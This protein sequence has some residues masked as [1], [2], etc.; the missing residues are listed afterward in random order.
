MHVV[1]EETKESRDALKFTDARTYGVFTLMFKAGA[2]DS[3][4]FKMI[5]FSKKGEQLDINMYNGLYSLM[6]KASEF[7]R[8][9]GSLTTPTCNELVWF[10]IVDHVYEL[11]T[12]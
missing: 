7:M 9:P 11:S 1:C 4:L 5:N 6:T 3:P 8:Y 2:N 12:T 10:H